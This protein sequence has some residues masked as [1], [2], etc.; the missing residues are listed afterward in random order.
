[1]VDKTSRVVVLKPDNIYHIT[2]ILF[3]AYMLG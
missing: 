3:K 1:M 2:S